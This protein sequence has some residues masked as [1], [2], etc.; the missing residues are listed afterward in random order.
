MLDKKDFLILDVLEKNA[1]LSTQQISRVTRIPITTVHN[2]IKKMQSE[3]VIEG[4]TTII[5][6]KKIGKNVSAYILIKVDYKELKSANK[7][8][9]ELAEKIKRLKDI[10]DVSI[11]AAGAD[12]IIKISSASIEDLNEF[13]VNKLRAFSGIDTTSTMVVLDDIKA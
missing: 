5:N 10:E 1:K 4:Y 3:G 9:K 12:I 8:Q 7:T 13:V 2:R 6:K 11:T